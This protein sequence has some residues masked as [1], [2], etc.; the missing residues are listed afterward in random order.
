LLHAL[1]D[2]ELDPVSAMALEQRIAAEPALE[3]AFQ[4]ILALKDKIANLERPVISTDFYERM[5]ALGSGA[6]ASARAP[7]RVRS[8]E[9][10]RNIAAALLV[11]ALVASGTT[12]LIAPHRAG[13]SMEDLV[14]ANHRRSLLAASPV[15]IVTS[16]R[17]T[18]KPW[19]DAKLGISPPVTDLTA[20]GYPLIGGR[21]DVI[22]ADAVPSLVYRHNE[23]LITLLAAP[24]SK[25]DA[26]PVSETAGGYN[27]VHWSEGGFSY[28][29]ISDLEAG[30]LRQFCADYRGV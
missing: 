3:A 9:G 21:V 18:V 17:H 27:I 16:D 5:A 1:A 10:W 20:K 22:G 26:L 25:A 6:P 28:W 14:A 8:I 7:V 11:T 30:E 24:G 2:G 23:H 12:Y 19:L 13:V 4:S 29:A 15:D